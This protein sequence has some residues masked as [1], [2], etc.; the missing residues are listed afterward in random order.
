M[1]SLLRSKAYVEPILEGF[2]A[3]IGGLDGRLRS[4]VVAAIAEQLSG[5]FSP[6]ASACKDTG[7]IFLLLFHRKNEVRTQP[8]LFLQSAVQPVQILSSKDNNG[9]VSLVRT[10]MF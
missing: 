7:R 10:M 4:S 9:S 6:P 5:P 3:S 1:A 2:V 8:V